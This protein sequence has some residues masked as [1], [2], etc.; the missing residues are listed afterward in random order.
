VR[1][2]VYPGTFDPFHNGHL[3]IAQR[4]AKLFDHLIVAV[5]EYPSKNALFSAEGRVEMVRESVK[6]LPNVEASLF[7]GLAV[8]YAKQMKA[9]VLIR[10]LR[11]ISDFEFEFEIAHM[12]RN[13]DSQLEAIFL[14]TSLP[15]AYLRSSIVKE[16]AQLGGSLKGLVPDHVDAELR[17]RDSAVSQAGHPPTSSLVP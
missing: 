12:N 14:M 10:G 2:A 3:D 8:V 4:A 11:A 1:I 13:L 9:C 6:D 5:Y 16:I 17:K 7:S 15:Y